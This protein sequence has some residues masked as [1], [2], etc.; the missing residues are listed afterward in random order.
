MRINF[1]R[2]TLLPRNS[3][4]YEYGVTPVT[5]P[6]KTGF[7]EKKQPEVWKIIR[8]HWDDTR[9]TGAEYVRAVYYLTVRADDDGLPLNIGYVWF[10]VKRRT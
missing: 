4:F 7:G 3:F 6:W 8:N 1:E 5:A 2:R 10:A 9:F